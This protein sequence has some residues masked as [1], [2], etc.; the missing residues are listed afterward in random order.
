MPSQ[1]PEADL[2]ELSSLAAGPLGLSPRP[3]GAPQEGTGES[4]P[5]ASSVVGVS[6][7]FT[8]YGR[9]SLS[10]AGPVQEPS[11]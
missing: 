9:P 2:C 11:A 5:T 8:L 1:A 10:L 6:I 3:M 4:Q 7:M